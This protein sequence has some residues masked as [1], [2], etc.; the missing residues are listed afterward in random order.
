MRYACWDTRDPSLAPHPPAPEGPPPPP[1]R[2]PKRFGGVAVGGCTWAPF[3]T[4][5][6]KGV[7]GE[8]HCGLLEG[9][10]RIHRTFQA[11]RVGG[12]VTQ[13]GLKR[14]LAPWR[15][16]RAG[17][18]RC[19]AQK[20]AK[21]RTKGKESSWLLKP[22]L[23]KSCRCTHQRTQ[24]SAGVGKPSMVSECASGCTWSTARAT[25][26][27]RDSQLRSSQTGQ[28]IQGRRLHKQNI[29]GPKQGQN[30]QWRETNRR[31]QRQTNQH[32]GLVPPP[33]PPP[34][35]PKYQGVAS[36]YTFA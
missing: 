36:T 1:F 3:V 7:K 27:L 8:G 15:A 28:V 13:K 30:V 24:V 26:Y 17:G 20:E 4:E 22:L 25:A 16:D 12:G 34:R 2:G 29:F 6:V 5:G 31:R 10:V 33:P 14:T 18:K 11:L 35:K 19:R 9:G 21:E 23:G 32:H